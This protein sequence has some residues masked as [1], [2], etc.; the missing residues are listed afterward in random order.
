MQRS[1]AGPLQVD[2]GRPDV[3]EGRT[4][5]AQIVEHVDDSVTAVIAA[6]R[7]GLHDLGDLGIQGAKETVRPRRGSNSCHLG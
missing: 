3:A 1:G 4:A 7:V 2:A 6:A 5:P